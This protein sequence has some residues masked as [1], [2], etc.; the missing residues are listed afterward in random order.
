MK[1][2]VLGLLL[3]LL[4][5]CSGCKKNMAYDVEQGIDKEVTLF[6]K[7]LPIPLGSAGPFTLALAME[8]LQKF[9]P[10]L[11]LP[12]NLLSVDE[13][14]LLLATDTSVPSED[15]LYRLAQ[16]VGDNAEPYLWKPDDKSLTPT[17][18]A[19]F[20]F[21]KLEMH[22]QQVSVSV[23][24]GLKDK[25]SFKG[26]LTVK[27]N[28]A[29]YKPVYEDAV[30]HSSLQLSTYGNK[31]QL[32]A[33]QIPE[34]KNA[35]TPAVT[36]SDV[37]I[38]LPAHL[39]TRIADDGFFRYHLTHKTNLS[40]GPAFSMAAPTINLPL[41]LPLSKVGMKEVEVAI[42]VE[43]TLPL[44]ITVTDIKVPDLQDLVVV[45][46][47]AVVKGGS[48][49]SPATSDLVLNFKTSDETHLPDLPSLSLEATVAAAPG[50]NNVLLAA[51]QGVTIKHAS[52]TIRGGVT[53]FGHE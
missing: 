42:K 43:S 21:L 39:G 28:D 15:N 40:F 6:E 25:V 24:T 44:D 4:L 34:G 14:G 27:C 46:G 52:V 17:F 38:S 26:K 22:N 50:L 11:G 9:L 23:S 37:E 8:P 2:I 19:I 36:V 33:F 47:D 51:N 53:L 32:A 13:N 10:T 1:K 7:E 49:E 41:D 20:S 12:A 35:T 18:A 29:D 3:P 16:T 48:P 31:V 45:T 5:L 30:E